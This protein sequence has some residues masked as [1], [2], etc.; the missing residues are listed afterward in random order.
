MAINLNIGDFIRQRIETQPNF[1][2]QNLPDMNQSTPDTTRQVNKI[3]QLQDKSINGIERSQSDISTQ[4]NNITAGIDGVPETNADYGSTGK[5]FSDHIKEAAKN[6]LM[7]T[8][9]DK[10]EQVEGTRV[11]A[12]HLS[13]P[14]LAKPETLT[15]TTP[16][17]NNPTHS[18]PTPNTRLT[19]TQPTTKMPTRPQLQMPKFRGK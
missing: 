3:T 2:S 16:I 13:N 9:S 18:T 7:G 11:S 5:G 4:S 12:Q 15:P 10:P 17:Q 8:M 19:Y 6:R 14:Q 1:R